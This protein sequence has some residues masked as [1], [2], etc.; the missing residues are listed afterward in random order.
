MQVPQPTL[1]LLLVFRHGHSVDPRGSTAAEATKRSLQSLWCYVMQQRSEPHPSVLSRC[2]VHPSKRWLQGNPAL[3]PDPGPTAR[4]PSE[5]AP[6]LS[7]PRCLRWLHWYYEPIRLPVSAR[8]CTPVFP[9]ASPPAATIPPDPTGPPGF[10]CRP[11]VRDAVLD[12]GGATPPR[13]ALAHMRP[14]RSG[15]RS[16]S[17][18]FSIS[19]LTCHTLHDLCLRFG[20]RVA[21]TPARLDPRLPATALAR[22]DFHLH[23]SISFAQRTPESCRKRNGVTSE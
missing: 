10:R 19:G 12:P 14:S 7:T 15:T 23:S 6:S 3:R 1:Q 17:A 8:R 21:T 5:S 16:A 4:D 2:H 22:E 13:I 18:V 20:P 11:F 9:R